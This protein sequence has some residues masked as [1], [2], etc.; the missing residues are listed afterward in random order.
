MSVVESSTVKPRWY[1]IPARVLLV[2]FVVTLI[3]FAL[4]LLFG[5]AGVIIAAIVHGV[6]PDMRFAYRNVAF[7]VAAIVG[8]IALLS[9]IVIETRHYYQART[10]QRIEQSS[11]R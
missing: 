6:H 9:A 1:L 3:S 2:T 7:P 8:V 10:L 5:I 11:A 4:S